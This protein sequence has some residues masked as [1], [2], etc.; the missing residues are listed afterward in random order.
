MLK[1]NGAARTTSRLQPL[2]ALWADIKPTITPLEQTNGVISAKES[3]SEFGFV[4]TKKPMFKSYGMTC[5]SSSCY[6]LKESISSYVSYNIA[7]HSFSLWVDNWI[8]DQRGESA[9]RCK[10]GI[11]FDNLD[12]FDCKFLWIYEQGAFGDVIR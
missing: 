12:Y 7:V 8:D 3:P 4:E 1:G 6:V 5:L 9:Q 2:R 10:M 11:F